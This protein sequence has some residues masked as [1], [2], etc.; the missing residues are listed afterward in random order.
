MRSFSFFFTLNLLQFQSEAF[1]PSGLRIQAK[2]GLNKI[3][4]DGALIDSG[5]VINGD[6]EDDGSGITKLNIKA[7][8]DEAAGEDKSSG[9]Q[10]VS[11]D[12]VLNEDELDEQ[13]KL[14]IAMMQ[15]AIQMA[16]SRYVLN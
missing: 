11:D 6:H 15:K 2:R 8:V 3:L 5:S 14:D 9:G 16:Q 10:I 12:M 13:S 7:L 4:K 1:G